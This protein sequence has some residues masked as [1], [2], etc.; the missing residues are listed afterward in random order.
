[1]QLCM[2]VCAWVHACVCAW[3]HVCVCAWVH[4]CVCAW[5]HA[6]VY[7]VKNIMTEQQYT[8][9]I[10]SDSK[11]K[12]QCKYYWSNNKRHW[13]LILPLSHF[14]IRNLDNT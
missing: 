7:I 6:C 3:V 13:L 11:P 1:M 10:I 4:A 14:L 9:H 8:P 5:V 12:A 2:C